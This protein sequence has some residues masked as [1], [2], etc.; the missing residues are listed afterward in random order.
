M[1]KWIALVGTLLISIV[2][3]QTIKTT[4]SNPSGNNLL[5]SGLLGILIIAG[6]WVFYKSDKKKP[7]KDYNGFSPTN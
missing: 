3:S 4:I 1:N 2:F 7:Q 6:I 5:I